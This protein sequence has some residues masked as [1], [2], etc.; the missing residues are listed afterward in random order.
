MDTSD[1]ILP[2]GFEMPGEGNGMGTEA[3]TTAGT[4]ESGNG[5]AAPEAG[6]IMPGG[7]GLPIPERVRRGAAGASP[8]PTILLML[9]TGATI[10]RQSS[11]RPIEHNS[12]P[13][14][15]PFSLLSVLQLF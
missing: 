12:R 2:E 1:M 10:P 5:P 3:G 4:T 9:M 14:G 15:R 13:F 8:R 6:F 11:V 7:E